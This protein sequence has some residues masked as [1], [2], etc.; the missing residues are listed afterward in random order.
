MTVPRLYGM[1]W[2]KIGNARKKF[3]DPVRIREGKGS[4]LSRS[5]NKSREIVDFTA[6][7]YSTLPKNGEGGYGIRAIW[8]G[9]NLCS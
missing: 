6:F 7:L 4:N 8:M 1:F 3:P 5:I 2:Q 9:S